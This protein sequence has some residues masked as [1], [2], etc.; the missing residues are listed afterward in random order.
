MIVRPSTRDLLAA[1]LQELSR[2]SPVDKI[3]VR[4]IADNC[5]LTAT[6]FYN[7]FENKYALMAWIY[8]RKVEQ[9]IDG[10]GSR[11]GWQ[12]ALYEFAALL[13]EDRT[14]Y[15]NALTNTEGMLSFRRSTNDAA[16]ERIRQRLVALHGEQPGDVLF[17]VKF[18]MRAVSDSI[19]AWFLRGRGR[20][21]LSEL[22][23][24]MMLGMPQQL[25]A[26]L[27]YPELPCPD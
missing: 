10:I 26:L 11:W 9:V 3:S 14:F 25:R 16:I 24:L 23:R 18:Y 17:L 8:N 7:H 2:S 1:S 20:E 27:E 12:Y 5:G 21:P 15:S 4:Q 6:T 22:V 13:E 19:E